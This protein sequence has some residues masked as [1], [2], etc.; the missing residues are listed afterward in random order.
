MVSVDVKQHFND[1]TTDMRLSVGTCIPLTGLG[2]W[3][4]RGA[5][6]VRVRDWSSKIW[7]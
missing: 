3:G 6:W 2:G 1:A 5:V 4:L 7:R